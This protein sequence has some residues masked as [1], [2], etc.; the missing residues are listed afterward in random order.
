MAAHDTDYD[1]AILGSSVSGRLAACIAA[2]K[3]ARVALIT[4]S[5]QA[6]DTTRYLLEALH[7]AEPSLDSQANWQSLKDWVY[8]QCGRPALSP[9]VLSAQ[10]IDVILESASFAQGPRLTLDN[11]HLKASR[12]L[13]TDGYDSSRPVFHSVLCS[14]LLQLERLPERIAV[15]GHGATALEWAYGLSR[16]TKVTL[17]LQDQWLLPAEDS[18]IQRL[19]TAQLRS[20]GIKVVSLDNCSATKDIS[21]KAETLDVDQLISVPQSYSWGAVAL[22]S[23]GIL[24]EASSAP[25]RVNPCL[26]TGCPQVYVSGGSLGGESRAELTRQETLVALD[27][28]LF[29][30]RQAMRYEQAFYSIKFLSPIGRWG[31]TERQARYCYGNDVAIF[32]ASCLPAITDHVAQTNFC[33]LI[34]LGQ[35]LLGVHLMGDGASALV[36]ALGQRPSM[37]TLSQWIMASFRSD[38]LQDAIYQAIAQWQS[39]RWRE[40]QW[41]RDWAENWFNFRRS[42]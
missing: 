1:V 31:L 33:K 4:P 15:I 20:L 11:R 24:S 8:Y 30:R 3:G 39:Y 13:L 41:R 32:K 21:I 38:T 7:N 17:I 35:R 42:L 2:Q 29:R 6:N 16:S 14:H 37:R 5:W 25:I 36:A 23:I 26:Q 27:N 9:T 40:G 22:P 18:D 10:G 19:V 28:A 12:Y 34:V